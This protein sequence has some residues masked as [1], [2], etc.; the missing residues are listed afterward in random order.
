MRYVYNF[1]Y[2]KELR[3]GAKYTLK[4]LAEKLDCSTR[5]LSRYENGQC[6]L[7]HELILKYATVF[8][9]FD[10]NNLYIKIDKDDL[11]EEVDN[12]GGESE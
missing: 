6:Y 10:I 9:D 3:Y 11:R 4:M 12:E 1:L 8:E 2:L 5:H 7:N